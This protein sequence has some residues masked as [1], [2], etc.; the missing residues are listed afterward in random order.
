[1]SAGKLG[2]LLVS[3]G[4]ITQQQLKAAAEHRA[5]NKTRLSSS[6]VSLGHVNE[7]VLATFLSK[8]Y[9]IPAISLDDVTIPPELTK[10]VPFSLCEKHMLVPLSADGNKLSIA[11]SDPT[12]VS[13][14]DDV[15]F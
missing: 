7:K 5:Q 10:L 15:R 2:D 1:M 6:L 3:Q 13:A 14:V 9:G 12:N 4:I 11:I 8:Q